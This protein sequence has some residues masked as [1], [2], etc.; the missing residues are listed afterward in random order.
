MF[1][2]AAVDASVLIDVGE[3]HLRPGKKGF[4][5]V[6]ILSDAS[7]LLDN[8][9]LQSQITTSGSSQLEFVTGPEIR[10]GIYG[11]TDP[12][13]GNS[14]YLFSDDSGAALYP[15]AGRISTTA[16]RNDTYIGDDRPDGQRHGQRRWR[17]SVPTTDTLDE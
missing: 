15:P 5:D 17:L 7:T 14:A 9:R 8:L 3:L 1:S 6:T 13:P 4:V 11:T 2:T 10:S 16:A 12:H